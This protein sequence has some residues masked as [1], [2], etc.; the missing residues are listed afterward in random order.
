MD[1][2][3]RIFRPPSEAESLLLQVSLGCSHNQ[4]SYCA[5]YD[6]PE[7]KFR[8]KDWKTVAEDI[9]EAAQWNENGAT[10]RRVFLC[11]GDALILPYGIADQR[12][13]VATVSVPELL[14]RLKAHSLI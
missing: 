12:C 13:R 5:M 1:H 9:A 3:G 4:C 14:T 10:I 2:V 8:I 6:H 11:D 7:Q